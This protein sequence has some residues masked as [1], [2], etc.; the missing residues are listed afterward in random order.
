LESNHQESPELVQLVQDTLAPIRE[1]EAA[2]LYELDVARGECYSSAGM[3]F[4][5]TSMGTF[6]ATA[7][8][9]SLSPLLLLLLLSLLPSSSIPPFPLSP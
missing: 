8:R 9:R 1:L 5:P 2:T 6:L 3:R 7:M 4:G